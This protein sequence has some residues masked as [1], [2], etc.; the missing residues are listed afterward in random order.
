MCGDDDD[1]GARP[2]EHEG[3]VLTRRQALQAGAAVALGGVVL[4]RA[5]GAAAAAAGL[6]GTEPFI[7]AMHVHACYSEGFGS[8]E[9]QY[10][11][12]K[13]TGVDVLFQT[14]HDF[15]A[16]AQDYMTQ[17][18]GTFV[19]ATTGT[20]A[21]H[22]AS[23]SPDGPIRVMVAAKGS[24]P[25]TQTLAME[26][27][28]TAWD[29][30]RTG[31]DGQTITHVF[32][33]SRLDAGA[34]YEVVLPL[35]VH[36]AKAGRPKGQYSLRY[37]FQKGATARR[38][39]EGKGLVGVVLAP[40]PATGTAVVFTPAADVAAIWPAMLAVDN[41]S[42]GLSFV[43][44][45]P[46]TGVVADVQLQRV[47]VNRARHDSA[48]VRAAQEAIRQRYSVAYGLTGF[49]SEEISMSPEPPE[50]LISFGYPPE[51]AVKQITPDDWEDWYGGYIGRVHAAGGA[52]SW[53]HPYGA[54]AGPTLSAA[55]Q[56]ALRRQ[57]YAQRSADDL[58]GADIMEVGYRVRGHMPIDQHLALWDTFSRRARFL[59][60]NGANDDHSGNPWKSLGN[61][62]QTGLWSASSAASDLVGALRGGR[63][64][65]F[66]PAQLPGLRLDTLV[67]G[68]VPMGAVSVGSAGSRT[69]A[70]GLGNL[71][72]GC[73]VELLRSPVDFSFAGSD[74]AV[75]V[76][77]SWSPA[78]GA[79]TLSAAVDTS[80]SCFVRAQVRRNGAIVGVG[81]P[82]WLVRTPPPGGV[83]P[84]RTA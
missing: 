72:A 70:I 30:F 39:T 62:F 35:S 26:E 45:S 65:T 43:V 64:Y 56:T 6:A 69:V 78:A 38:F 36:P 18:S 3:R 80:S 74:P 77:G 37:R 7:A 46:R 83:P 40:M 44:T 24:S 41:S 42:Y 11:N 17:L 32:G 33:T 15:R 4:T 52:V 14:D 67:D 8:W 1:E 16:V 50:H 51:F 19:P 55:D 27:R 71:P 79:P 47:V 84:E 76:V 75:T 61:G 25:A 81:N 49:V 22:A 9:Q 60:G 31:I 53:N 5:G 68:A 82:T 13:A 21:Q 10:A 59:T 63:A 66:H 73:T 2:H 57:V 29:H 58:L 54:S 23:F 28:P 48:G 20:W 34:K 12:A